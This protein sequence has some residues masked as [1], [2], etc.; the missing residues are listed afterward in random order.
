[1]QV[2]RW[3]SGADNISVAELKSECGNTGHIIVNFLKSKD[4]VLVLGDVL[5]SITLLNYDSEN[6]KLEEVARDFSSNYMRGIE[7]VDI[8]TFIGADDNA[9][10]FFV[11]RDSSVE[12]TADTGRLDLCGEFHVGDLINVF[13]C[14]SLSNRPQELEASR[15]SKDRLDGCVPSGSSILFGTVSGAI[16]TVLSID[17]TSYRLFAALQKCI[18]TVIYSIGG[19]PHSDWR[20]FSNDKRF[21]SQKNVVDGDLIE[22]FLELTSA[23][24]TRVVALL[25]DELCSG[26]V[27]G[28][29]SAAAGGDGGVVTLDMVNNRI[30]EMARCH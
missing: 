2:F 28:V 13:Q 7:V 8:N 5:Q 24:K 14:G 3:C 19:L 30:Q 11:R 16:G 18:Q 12:K 22:Q 17:A 15:E 6:S 25:N 20:N 4:G 9:N 23:E 21:G 10:I 27:P 29:I 26:T 1:M